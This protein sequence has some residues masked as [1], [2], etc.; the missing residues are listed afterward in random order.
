[1]PILQRTW[2]LSE[3]LDDLP[4]ISQLLRMRAEI[5]TQAW[6]LLGP[7]SCCHLSDLLA[8]WLV[9]PGPVHAGRVLT[10]H[11]LWASRGQPAKAARPRPGLISSMR[12]HA[13]LASNEAT[14]N[15]W[16]GGRA[17]QRLTLVPHAVP[18]PSW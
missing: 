2:R 6:Q 16:G 11:L 9:L 13:T 3:V 17:R 8:K 10:F 7:S 5:P 14:S 4:K 18:G 15:W 1:M 12:S